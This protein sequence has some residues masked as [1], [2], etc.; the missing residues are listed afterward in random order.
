MRFNH[1]YRGLLLLYPADFRNQF[2]EEMICVFEQRAGERLASRNSATFVFV[3]TELSGIL[4]GAC[5][6]WLAKI[7]TVRRNS[8]SA[9]TS[10]PPAA[11]LTVAEAIKRRD[12]AIKK[13]V[14]SIAAHDFINARR[15]SEE[16]TR[17][18]NLLQDLE[19]GLPIGKSRTA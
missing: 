14:A 18:K 16:E 10:N 6:M 7:L 17:L 2:S 4:K 13:M 1:I 9:D 8:S 5:T 15:Y 3:V 19:N 11:A 12:A